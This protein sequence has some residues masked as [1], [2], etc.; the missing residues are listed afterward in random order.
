[1]NVKM[2]TIVMGM[3][4]VP[5]TMD[6]ISAHVTLGSLE[7]ERTAQILM[8]VTKTEMIATQ[9]LPA[10]IPMEPSLVPVTQDTLGMEHTVQTLMNALIT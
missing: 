5:T 10:L 1:M 8:S 7:M 4:R 6:H 9:M 3:P 2:P